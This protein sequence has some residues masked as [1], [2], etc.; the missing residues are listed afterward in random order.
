MS[1]RTEWEREYLMAHPIAPKPLG[2]RWYLG[3][4]GEVMFGLVIV[5]VVIALL[6]LV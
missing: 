4:A 3:L 2:W 1:S 5:L 6:S